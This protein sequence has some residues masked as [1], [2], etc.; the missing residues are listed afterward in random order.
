MV[1]SGEGCVSDSYGATAVRIAAELA[2]PPHERRPEQGTVARRVTIVEH[3]A[4]ASNPAIQPGSVPRP[5]VDHGLEPCAR[6]G[7]RAPAVEG[8]RPHTSSPRSTVTACPPRITRSP[9][10]FTRTTPPRGE[11]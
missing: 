3:D 7:R 11:A 5:T 10:S 8:R 2:K 9:T 6:V 1:K 4:F